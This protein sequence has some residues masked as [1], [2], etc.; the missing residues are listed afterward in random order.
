[1]LKRSFLIVLFAV[2]ASSLVASVDVEE[3]LELEPTMDQRRATSIA[4]RCLTNHHYK[5]TRLDDNL[6]G[7]IF[8]VYLELLDPN[9]I[10]FLQSDIE[11]F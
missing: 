9:K 3:A 6:S 8:D 5:P 10:Y 2:L 4:T 7:E 1:M 11:N